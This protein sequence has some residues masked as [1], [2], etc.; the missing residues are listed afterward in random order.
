M[1][2]WTSELRARLAD[3]RLAAAR[4]VSII[5]ELAQHLAGLD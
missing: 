1:H 4:E 5:A 2:D 3:L